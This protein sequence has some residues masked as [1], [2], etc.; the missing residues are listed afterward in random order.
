MKDQKMIYGSYGLSV[1]VIS[2]GDSERQPYLQVI[3]SMRN[4]VGE[5]FVCDI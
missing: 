5:R 4:F 2:V 3:D 1:I